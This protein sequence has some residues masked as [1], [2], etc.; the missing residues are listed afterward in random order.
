METPIP[1]VWLEPVLRILREGKFVRD[2]LVPE[3]VRN[4]WDA[5]SLGTAFL[6]DLREPIIQALSAEGVIGK[7]QPDQPEPGET[8][9]FWFH[10]R[11]AGRD[12]K[13]YGK[14]CLYPDK[15]RIKLISAH[16]PDKGEKFL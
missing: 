13:F 12:R 2:I 14:I 10:Y 6:W 4:D 11:V 16:L 3:R 9:A 5:G 15:V 8:Y 7:H 1:Q